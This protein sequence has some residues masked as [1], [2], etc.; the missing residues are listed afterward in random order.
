M[1]CSLDSEIL[2]SW[3]KSAEMDSPHDTGSVRLK[4]S[5]VSGCSWQEVC[6]PDFL[7]QLEKAE[8]RPTEAS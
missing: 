2:W 3:P 5:G 1:I 8:D 7:A 4:S 6:A